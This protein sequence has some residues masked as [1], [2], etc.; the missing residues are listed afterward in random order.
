MSGDYFQNQLI[1][2]I[3]FNQLINLPNNSVIETL[4]PTGFVYYRLTKKQLLHYYGEKQQFNHAKIL[5]ARLIVGQIKDH[6]TCAIYLQLADKKQI[7]LPINSKKM[8]NFLLAFKSIGRFF[9]INY[10]INRRA[11]PWHSELMSTFYNNKIYAHYQRLH[12][13]IKEA[14]KIII[15]DTD[16]AELN[17]V[18]GGC[19]TGEFLINIKTQLT[20]DH[21]SLKLNLFGFDFST[22]NIDYCNKLF[23]Q[24]NE[25]PCRIE[26]GNL[27]PTDEVLQRFSQINTR[28]THGKL[29]LAKQAKTVL[30][31]SGSLTRF[32]LND[33]FASLESLQNIINSDRV[34]FLVGGGLGEPLINHYMAKRIGYKKKIISKIWQDKLLENEP[35]TYFF[36]YERMSLE[37]ILA[38]N[39]K[40]Y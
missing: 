12:E 6:I 28:I 11:H 38:S 13:Q 14:L 8:G 37:E 19:G 24:Q 40:L 15:K 18:D 27:I 39:D 25:I 10:K 16:S 32:V 5:E 36:A 33:S 35:Q 34:D 29:V 17:I 7:L 9:P 21:I 4:F 26:K 1:K 31:L 23:S 3:D 2:S 30:T 22:Q 20:K